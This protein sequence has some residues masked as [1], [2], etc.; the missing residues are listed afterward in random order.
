MGMAVAMSRLLIQ[1]VSEANLSSTKEKRNQKN[2]YHLTPPYL[3]E[4]PKELASHE[5]EY[6]KNKLSWQTKM[7][8]H[9]LWVIFRVSYYAGWRKA[10]G[11]CTKMP[12]KK[13]TDYW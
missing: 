5:R 10:I 2:R 9:I 3:S 4:I 12:H 6:K 7:S 1:V 11:N 8:F 13:F